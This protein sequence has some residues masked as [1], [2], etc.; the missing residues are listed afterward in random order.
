MKLTSLQ[1]QLSGQVPQFEGPLPTRPRLRRL[2]IVAVLV[3]GLVVAF[4]WLRS[5]KH[6]A[7][8]ETS[9]TP[10]VLPSDQGI[11]NEMIQAGTP[12]R[13]KG[14]AT[15]PQPTPASSPPPIPHHASPISPSNPADMNQIIE[16]IAQRVDRR[17]ESRFGKSFTAELSSPFN[18]M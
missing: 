13:R 16:L 14:Q 7:N 17:E 18:V 2:P 4:F 8:H 1:T 6:R 9:I 5:Q 10:L 15:W 12:P 11:T 3:L